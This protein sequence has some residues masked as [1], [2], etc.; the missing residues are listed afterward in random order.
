MLTDALQTTEHLMPVH[1]RVDKLTGTIPAAIREAV[2]VHDGDEMSSAPKMGIV[3]TRAAEHCRASLKRS[4]KRRLN[5]CEGGHI[6]SATSC[7]TGT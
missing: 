4:T 6:A 7:R 1:V 2:T 5:P 3:M